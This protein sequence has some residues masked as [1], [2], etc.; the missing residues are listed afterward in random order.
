MA[1]KLF[2]LPYLTRSRVLGHVYLL[3]VVPLTWMAFAITDARQIGVYFSRLFP[4]FARAGQAGNPLD[5]VRYMGDYAPLFLLGIVFATPV[6]AALY[7][8][9]RKKWVSG[10]A[11]MAVLVL[12]MYYMSISVNNPF[13]YFNF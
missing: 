12:A 6:P 13:L 1:E 5:Y 7:R 8:A 11:V 4:F 10:A 9:F 2:L 3:I